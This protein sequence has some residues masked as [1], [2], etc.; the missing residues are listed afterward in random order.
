MFVPVIFF[1]Y[2]FIFSESGSLKG[3]NQPACKRK[4]S[5]QNQPVRKRKKSEVVIEEAKKPSIF[6]RSLFLH[7]N[8]GSKKDKKGLQTFIFSNHFFSLLGILCLLI[9]EWIRN[10]LLFF[11]P[12]IFSFQHLLKFLCFSKHET[13]IFFNLLGISCQLIFQWIWNALLFFGSSFFHTYTCSNCN[14]N[15]NMKLSSFWEKITDCLFSK[16]QK[17]RASKMFLFQNK[18]K[19]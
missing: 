3:Q 18:E 10:A 4:K 5:G 2:K 1:V 11:W 19:Q 15:Q 6:S 13:V 14:V 16:F 8:D 12:L 7:Y 17:V 9:F